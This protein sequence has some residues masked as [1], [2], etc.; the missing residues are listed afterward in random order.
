VMMMRIPTWGPPKEVD[1]YLPIAD[2]IF[3][4]DQSRDVQLEWI[5]RLQFKNGQFYFSYSK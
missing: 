1:Q 4:F 5:N 3:Y 2:K